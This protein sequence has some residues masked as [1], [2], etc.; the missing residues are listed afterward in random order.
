[1]NKKYTFGRFLV[2]MFLGIITCGFYWV[3]M[4]FKAMNK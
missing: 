1:M 4:I 3:W 2:D